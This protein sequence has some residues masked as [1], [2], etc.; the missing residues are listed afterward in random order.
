LKYHFSKIIG[1]GILNL[2][3]VIYLSFGFFV[4]GS[5]LEEKDVMEMTR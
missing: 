1:F 2:T 5:Y 3:I 4:I